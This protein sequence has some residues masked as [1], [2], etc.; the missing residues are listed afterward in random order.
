MHVKNP[1]E[2]ADN[3]QTKTDKKDTKIIAQLIK[4]ARY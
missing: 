2:F 3:N 1:K 4:D